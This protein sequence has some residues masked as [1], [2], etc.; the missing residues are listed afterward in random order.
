MLTKI[1][2][3]I[4]L[5]VL[6]NVAVAQNSNVQ[7]LD[8][9]A[10][11]F[12]SNIRAH[13]KQRA[14]LLSDK[15]VYASAESIW[16]K[17]FL[18][19]TVSQ[20]RNA[21]TSFLFVDL[22]NE[23]DSVIKVVILDAFNQQLNS[24]IVLPDTMVPG[25]YWLRA[26]TKQMAAVDTDNI[27]VK[28]IV[29]VDIKTDHDF[30][31]PSKGNN[32]Q[33]S[34]PVVLFYPE[35]GN[36][37]TGVNSTVAI[38]LKDKN[39]NPLS[40]DG[41]IKDHRDSIITRFTTNNAGVGKFIFEPSG[42]R[43]Y[44]AVIR[45]GGKEAFYPL[46]AFDF[47][48]GQLSVVKESKGYKVKVLLGDSIYRKDPLTNIIGLCKDSL[49]FAGI[50]TGQYEVFV[51]EQKLPAGI[52]TFYLFDKDFNF[53]SERSVFV[54]KN[55]LQIQAATDKN[56]Y[57]V[58]EKVKLNISVPVSSLITV[59]VADSVL[60]HTQQLG[61][62][63]GKDYRGGIDNAVLADKAYFDEEE[64][65]LLMLLI[66]NTYRKYDKVNTVLPDLKPD[67]LL[68]IKGQV[69][70]QKNE[71][72]TG[73][74]VT[75]LSN[76]GVPFLYS[77]TTDNLG[78]FSFPFENYSDSMQFA[79]EVKSL[80]G[81]SENARIAMDVLVY[82][83]FSTPV[84]L[85]QFPRIPIRDIKKYIRILSE[86]ELIGGEKKMLPNVTVKDNRQP[87][88]YNEAKRVS[89]NSAILSADDLD[90]KNGVGNAVLKIGGMHMLNGF[91]VVNGP[92]AMQAP[93]AGSEPLIMVEGSPVSTTND[94]G[95]DASPAMNYLNSLNPR[96]IDFIEIL[97][98]GEGA[99]YGVRGG[100]GVILINLVS[101]RR[102]VNINSNKL[103][104]FYAKGISNPVMFQNINY[105][106]KEPKKNEQVDT[107]ST[108][109][110]DGNFQAGIQ[111]SAF[112]FYT[113]DTPATY[114]VSITGITTTGD[115]I[116]KTFTFKTK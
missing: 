19:N 63:A 66:Q 84:S 103:K 81:R 112:T 43:K 105:Q 10:G 98:G 82:P 59:A 38:L 100:N 4:L 28:P 30:S 113:G 57:A 74:I 95:G 16:F 20:K 50:G 114:K 69:F 65:N 18:L 109:Y 36:I 97:K 87:V 48:A 26:Y 91:L 6:C 46:P 33:D 52:T 83:K 41:L 24:R 14:Y 104:M 73:K 7:A 71:P 88:N 12:I 85:K 25:Y 64:I 8:S 34:T 42:F 80:N 11:K 9:F 106:Q 61:T 99:N 78:R 60:S 115:V 1:L 107:R 35:G 76:S 37:I 22:V 29:I 116:C 3:S 23:K 110:W 51:E 77:D 79:L 21:N 49:V 70:T 32:G 2:L 13:E 68:Y 111:N 56:S 94:G 53:L 40:S 47:R 89:P 108:L 17:A 5:M 67:S 27:C 96:D 54:Q 45:R 55:D 101:T 75:I 92:T 86:N 90:E 44:G 62:P 102:D 15:Y 72:A 39:G 58:K 31:L 93:N